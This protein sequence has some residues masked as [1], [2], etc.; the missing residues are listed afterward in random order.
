[1]RIETER[2]VLRPV[3]LED[4]PAVQRQVARYEIARNLYTLP[5]PY[6]EDG[7][8]TWL[9]GAAERGNFAIEREGEL[10]GVMS[11]TVTEQDSRAELGY[12]VAVEEWGKGYATEAARALIDYAFREL[13]LNRVHAGVFGDNPGSQRVLEKAGMKREGV[14][15]QHHFRI[16]RMCDLVHYGMLRSDWSAPSS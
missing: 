8:E 7:A 14:R 16:D 5:W 12:W 1:V 15:P 6:P 10:I 11:L 13:G 4:A 2:L 9:R 3:A